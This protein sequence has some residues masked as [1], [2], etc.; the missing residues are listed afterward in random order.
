MGFWM[1]CL[2]LVTMTLGEDFDTKT[3]LLIDGMVDGSCGDGG[4]VAEGL[5]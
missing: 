1:L 5:V 2:E 3:G 4:V